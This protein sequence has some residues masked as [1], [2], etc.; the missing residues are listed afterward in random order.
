MR[1]RTSPR[2]LPAA[3]LATTMLTGLAAPAFA[4]T[5][6]EEVVVT[7]QKRS[8]NLQD[9]P[10]SIQALGTEKLDELQVSDFADY[11]KF[12]PSVT[13]KSSGPGFS[14]VYM[15]G[16][17][18]GENNNH[19]GP[20]PSVGVYLDEQPVTT[21][22]GPLDIHVYDIA[23]VEVLAG[24]QGTLYGASSQAGTIRII[25]NKPSAAG[26]EAG[27]DLEVNHLSHGAYG[28][29]AEGF[30]NQ[31]LGDR[32][33]VRLVG[34][35]VHDGGY[36]DNVP[37]SFTYPTGNITV[38]NAAF[39]EGN[40][41][42]VDTAGARAALK[43]DLNDNW[44]VTPT[45]MG[46]RTQA[47]GGFAINPALGKFKN[48]R[49]RPEQSDDKWFQASLTVEGKVSNLDLT[50]AGAYMKRWVDTESDYSDYSYFYDTLFGYGAYL[51]DDGGNFID[52]TQY[53]QGKDYYTKQSHEL[54]LATPTDYRLHG[55]AGLFYQKQTH[56][57]QQRYR[58]DRLATAT[59]VPGWPDTLWL[60]KQLR[61]DRDYAA[62]VDGTFDVT[63]QLSVTGGIRFFKSNNSL[64]GFFGFGTGYSS[65]TGVAACFGPAIVEGGPCTN[66][67]KST[68]E[69]GETYRV[70]AQYKIDEDKMVYATY[71]TGFRPGGINRRGTLPPYKS[72]YLKN[73]EAGWK[74]TWLGGMLRWNGAV[75]SEKWD[76]FQFSFLGAN[77]L[78]EIRN[79][80]KAKMRGVESDINWL[81]TEGLTLTGSAAY[82]KA[83]LDE[84][85]IPDPSAPPEALKGTTLP[86]TPKFKANL[87][88]RY[89]WPIGEMDAHVQGALAYT[90]SNYPDLTIDDRAVVGKIPSYTTVDL[91]TGLERGSWRV[92]A[93]VKN[94]F[95]EDGALNKFVQCTSS[96]CSR[97][98]TIP[99]RPRT[100]GF[101]FGQSF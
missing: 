16:V 74:T 83:E 76:D 49:F 7:A 3:L 98:Y 20:L 14:T 91:T 27:Y 70:N 68:K 92:E 65:R 12:L 95:D 87:V 78:T 28:S 34:W 51:T 64:E 40:Y 99:I 4:Q 26:F 67:D 62:F 24:P 56:N 6:L 41:N 93:Y 73:L 17:A 46:Q 58:V 23:R 60:T 39:V 71:S 13:I 25:T 43:I 44:T 94:L 80:G 97:V 50:Y 8:E 1:L 18:S 54:R 53:I 72:D 63:D 59:E 11:V 22:T 81:V 48:S 55:V 37:G 75:Y 69:T 10:I 45:L 29:S 82:T 35:A 89:E 30:V 33:A 38:N 36:I 9:V 79:A 61:T 52:T 5:A 21:I 96:V 32:A 90:G 77:G 101:R 57:I 15:R 88:A 86:I 84:D 19:S 31:P 2:A 42:E 100:I 85:Y 66:V 47:D